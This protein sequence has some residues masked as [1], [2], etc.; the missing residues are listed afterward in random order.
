MGGKCANAATAALNAKKRFTDQY[1]FS[2]IAWDSC[3]G[4]LL[5]RV[6]A[7]GTDERQALLRGSIRAC[8]RDA[9]SCGS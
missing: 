2:D 8:G 6:A 9:E 4:W 7:A 1:Q 3:L 5:A